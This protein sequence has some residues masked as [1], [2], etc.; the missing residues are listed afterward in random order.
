MKVGMCSWK[1]NLAP[2][3]KRATASAAP[4][5]FAGSSRACTTAQAGPQRHDLYYVSIH[6]LSCLWGDR[7]RARHYFSPGGLRDYITITVLQACMATS[8]GKHAWRG[9]VEGTH[10]KDWWEVRMATSACPW[11]ACTICMIV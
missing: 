7:S 8:G 6:S 1:S 9:V 10:G 5:R 4:R 2:P 3:Q 11:Q